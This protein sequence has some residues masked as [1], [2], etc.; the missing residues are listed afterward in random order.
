MKKLKIGQ[1]GVRHEHADGKMNAVRIQF[2]DVFEV[3]GIAAESPEWQEK[4][5]DN[6]A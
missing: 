4:L 5:R 1:T 3:V 2:H 6:K